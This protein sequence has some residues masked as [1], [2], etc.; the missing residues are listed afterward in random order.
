MGYWC[1]KMDR[2]PPNVCRLLARVPH[3]PKQ[4]LTTQEIAQRAGFSKQKVRAI[5][6]LR[7]WRDVSVG[8]Q[9]RFKAA[10][11]IS[12]G[13]GE[14]IQVG[15]LKRTFNPQKTQ[16]GLFHLRRQMKHRKDARLTRYFAELMRPKE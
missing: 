10:C 16:S 8:D 12:V 5:S 7:T 14:A 9:E 11:G 1:E 15:Y 13:R 6:R 3:K 4:A 2:L